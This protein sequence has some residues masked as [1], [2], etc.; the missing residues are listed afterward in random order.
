MF[1]FCCM[2]EVF[3]ISGAGLSESCT[4]ASFSL[5]AHSLLYSSVVMSW[6]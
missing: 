5:Q 3:G 6:W 1:S 4:D 2:S